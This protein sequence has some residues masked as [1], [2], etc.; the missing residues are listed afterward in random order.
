MARPSSDVTRVFHHRRFLV[1]RSEFGS[2]TIHRC[3]LSIAKSCVCVC[4]PYLSPRPSRDSELVCV[5]WCSWCIY[6]DR[7]RSAAWGGWCVDS[8]ATPGRI[9]AVFWTYPSR[10]SASSS[11]IPHSPSFLKVEACSP[12]TRNVFACVCGQTLKALSLWNFPESGQQK[13]TALRSSMLSS[14]KRCVASSCLLFPLFPAFRKLPSVDDIPLA[15]VQIS[16]VRCL[17]ELPLVFS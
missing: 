11:S 16:C 12:L 10:N 3:V 17:Q 7:L 1:G 8:S 5:G 2:C 9:G 13:D 14:S 6:I 15:I 4:C